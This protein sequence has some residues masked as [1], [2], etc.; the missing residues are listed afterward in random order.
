MPNFEF[1]NADIYRTKGNDFGSTTYSDV[2]PFRRNE[3]KTFKNF[4]KNIRLKH[5]TPIDENSFIDID[6]DRDSKGISFTKRF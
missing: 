4:A 3:A 1:K 5:R 6:F 2:Q